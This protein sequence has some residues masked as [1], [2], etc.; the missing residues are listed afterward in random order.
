[1]RGRLT[2]HQVASQS[3]HR[4]RI[5]RA[6][7]YPRKKASAHDR[8]RTHPLQQ[9]AAPKFTNSKFIPPHLIS[10]IFFSETSAKDKIAFLPR[11]AAARADAPPR[12]LR[13]EGDKKSQPSAARSRK[14]RTA[15]CQLRLLGSTSERS[16]VC[17]RTESPKPFES[18][19]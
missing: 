9:Q 11:P 5:P 8:P 17:S 12:G 15:T 6:H 1:M 4:T 13:Q 7:A 2:K 10:L 19:F 3:G 14:P 16:V 18:N